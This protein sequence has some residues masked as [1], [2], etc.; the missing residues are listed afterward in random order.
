MRIAFFSMVCATL[1]GLRPAS[2]QPAAG[3]N[4]SRT[5]W[6]DRPARTFNGGQTNGLPFIR[7][8]GN[9]FVDPDGKTVLFRGVSISDPDKIERQGH[10]NKE[11]FEKVKELGTTLVRIPVHPQAWR[12]RGP[13]EYFKL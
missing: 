5:W 4:D 6:R 11:H 12:D 10:W 8:Q 2:A 3:T 1:L 13:R 9:K 7:V